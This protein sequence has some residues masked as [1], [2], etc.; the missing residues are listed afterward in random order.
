M[1]VVWRVIDSVAL[2]K[3]YFLAK[4]THV[5]SRAIFTAVCNRYLLNKLKI[6]CKSSHW[7]TAETRAGHVRP[8][9]TL[10]ERKRVVIAHVLHSNALC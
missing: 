2:L 7:A 6:M 10:R 5:K 1:V 4:L 8:G 3:N 9:D